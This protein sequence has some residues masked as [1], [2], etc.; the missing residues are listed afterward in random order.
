VG[1]VALPPKP[2]KAR[3]GWGTLYLVV[4]FSGQMFRLRFAPLNMTTDVEVVGDALARLQI[5]WKKKE[6]GHRLMPV[7]DLLED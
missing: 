7:L 6:Y 4:E 5:D 1:S 2:Q 3:L